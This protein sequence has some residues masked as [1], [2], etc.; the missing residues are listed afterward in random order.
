[1]STRSA[2]EGGGKMT[3]INYRG[4][5]IGINSAKFQQTNIEGKWDL[6]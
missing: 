2:K 4:Q 3:L 6:R 1:M 5:V